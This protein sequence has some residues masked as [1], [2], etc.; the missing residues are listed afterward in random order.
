MSPTQAKPDPSPENPHLQ[1]NERPVL[2]L[3]GGGALGS[4]QAGVYEA[5]DDVQIDPVWVAGISIGAINAAIIA[6]NEPAHRVE[7]LQAFWQDVSSNLQGLLP[8]NDST[9]RGFFNSASA[10]LTAAFGVPGFFVP[11]LVP[12]IFQQPGTMAALSYYDTKPLRATLERHIDFDRINAK[13]TRL[14]VGA[15]NVR[16]GNFVYF[17]NQ[18][19]TIT[20]EHIMASGAL[21]PGFPPVE[22]DGEFYW[23]G[24]LVSNT[25]LQYVLDSD[26]RHDMLIFQVDLFSARGP[27]PTTMLEANERE[28]DIRYSSR[29]RLNTDIFRRHHKTQLALHNLLEKLPAELA[30]DPDV[31]RLRAEHNDAAITIVHL[32]HR[33][34][35]YQQSTKDFEFS[36]ASMT[37]HW[38]A[39]KRDVETTL[40]SE[41]WKARGRPLHDVA[42][43]DMTQKTPA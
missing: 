25:P 38:Q 41:A 8:G 10:S 39:G 28:K 40:A 24:G 17:D 33:R 43:F 19:K 42:V 2:V 18:T 9:W 27:M 4:Y 34:R 35:S 30:D 6:G 32:I 31:K 37:D 14:S 36:R 29:T 5:L 3:Q 20:P 12:P 23:D 21:P 15:V 22:V 13:K 26:P 11:R 1:C 16:S 7:K